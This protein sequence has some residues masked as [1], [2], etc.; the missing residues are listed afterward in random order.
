MIIDLIRYLNENEINT[1]IVDENMAKK[2]MSLDA[3]KH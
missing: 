2:M 3:D 1:V